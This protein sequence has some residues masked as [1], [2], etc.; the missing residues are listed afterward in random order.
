MGVTAQLSVWQGSCSPWLSCPACFWW[1]LLFPS[2]QLLYL[3]LGST[4]EM[5]AVPQT[6][7]LLNRTLAGLDW[8]TRSSPWEESK[9]RLRR[10]GDQGA[11]RTAAANMHSLM[12]FY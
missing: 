10:S 5:L 3:E 12:F 7:P 8:L 6:S 4:T 9:R 11:A 1:L 2:T